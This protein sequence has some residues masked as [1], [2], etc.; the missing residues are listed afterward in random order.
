MHRWALSRQ[1]PSLHSLMR[2]ALAFVAVIS[3]YAALADSVWADDPNT[4]SA[5]LVQSSTQALQSFLRNPKWESLRNLLGGARAI[6]IVPHDVAGGFLVTASG[7][8]GVL[9]RRH[10]ETWSDPVF[11]HI[12]S[13]GVG[14]EGGAETQSIVMVIM[15]DTG[16]ENLISGVSQVGGSGGFALAN[17]GVGGGGSGGLS[18][19]LQVLTVS[20]AKGLYAGG[21]IQGTKMSPQDAYNKASYGAGYSM[22]GIAA[23][24]GGRLPAAS[25]LRT[26]L[27]KAVA[28]AWGR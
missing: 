11:M 21:G 4:R 16:V 19:G 12:G 5:A 17:L 24:S 10:G 1:T 26:E 3:L 23:G 7:G 25:G 9:L 28:Q 14:F 15:T 22:A 2:I 13:V 6:F 8:D 20:S 18:G 27:A